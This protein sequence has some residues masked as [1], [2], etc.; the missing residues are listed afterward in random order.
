V[1]T[2]GLRAIVLEGEKKN[3]KTLKKEKKRKKRMP[4]DYLLF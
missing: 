3:Q 4:K 1:E 2:C